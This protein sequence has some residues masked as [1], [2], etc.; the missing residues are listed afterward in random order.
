MASIRAQPLA[1]ALLFPLALLAAQVYVQRQDVREARA[2]AASDGRVAQIQVSGKLLDTSIAAYFEAIGELGLAERSIRSPGS[3]ALKPV[4]TAQA[5]VM[6]TRE[7]ARKALKEHAGDIHSL[8]DKLPKE[9]VERYL[10]QLEAISDVIDGDPAIETIGKNT[11][12]LGKMVVAR[13]ALVDEA[14]AKT[15]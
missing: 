6:S 9:A 3:F 1:T 10:A 11:T 12:A 2:L 15:S 7:A 8:H 14:G 13:D 4:A 5:D